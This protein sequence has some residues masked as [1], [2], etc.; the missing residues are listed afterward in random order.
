MK[1]NISYAIT[2]IV[3]GVI[4]GLLG[5][6]FE[7]ER[8]IMAGLAYG[9][10]PTGIG[11]LLMYKYA[12]KRPQMLKNIELEN[13]ERNVFINFKA[14]HTAFWISYWYIICAVVFS[15]IVN[16]SFKQFGILTMFFM[17]IVYFI[18]VLIYHKKY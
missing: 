11:L 12:E 3:V 9:F 6:I 5:I 18:F 1:K 15:N 10:T 17:P 4:A 2:F 7:F 8:P 16:L 14:G 13:E